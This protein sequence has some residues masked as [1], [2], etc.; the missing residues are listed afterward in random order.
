MAGVV[1][2]V[3]SALSLWTADLAMG[4]LAGSGVWV[5]VTWWTLWWNDG[6]TRT[7]DTVM[8]IDLPPGPADPVPAAVSPD[9]AP[10]P[11]P[12]AA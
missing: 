1:A 8:N 6:R 7:Q 9:P 12:V 4:I 5:A 2:V 3:L 10:D 11:A